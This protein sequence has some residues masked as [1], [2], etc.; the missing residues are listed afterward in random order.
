E[1]LT[2]ERVFRCIRNSRAALRDVD[3]TGIDELLAWPARLARALVVR[4]VPG[5]DA[6]AFLAGAEMLVEPVAAHGRGRNDAAIFVVLVQHLLR[7]AVLPRRKPERIGPGIG[8][9]LALYA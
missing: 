1:L 7:M 3:G 9:A 5:G 4:P 6:K 2:D 8:V